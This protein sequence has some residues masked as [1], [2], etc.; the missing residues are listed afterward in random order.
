MARRIVSF[1][2]EDLLGTP[3]SPISEQRSNPPTMS[4]TDITVFQAVQP[5]QFNNKPYRRSRPSTV[6][7]RDFANQPAQ[8]EPEPSDEQQEPMEDPTEQAITRRESAPEAPTTSPTTDDCMAPISRTDSN[9]SNRSDASVAGS[10]A[11]SFRRRLKEIRRPYPE[12]TGP[13]RGAPRSPKSPP[14]VGESGSAA[15]ERYKPARVPTDTASAAPARHRTLFEVLDQTK[16]RTAQQLREK[17]DMV[18]QHL[19]RKRKE[20]E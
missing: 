5:V 7:S 12:V 2:P 9:L 3:L 1:T 18:E 20:G 13:P 4:N 6:I 17:M 19:R 8:T 11:S 10:T 16:D 15:Q 14:V